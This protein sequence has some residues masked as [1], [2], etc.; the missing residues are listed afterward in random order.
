MRSHL[1][2]VFVSLSYSPYKIV[3]LIT[4]LYHFWAHFDL[5]LQYCSVLG[6]LNQLRLHI[7]EW[8]QFQPWPIDREAF[9]TPYGVETE[10]F[11]T[12]R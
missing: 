1:K 5:E 10:A 2:L 9:T 7:T 3:L 11:S 8:R 4:R 6:I 12:Q